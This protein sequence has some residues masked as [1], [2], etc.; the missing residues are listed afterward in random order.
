MH[1]LIIVKLSK[2]Y[3]IAVLGGLLMITNADAAENLSRSPVRSLDGTW[4]IV[5]DGDDAGLKQEWGRAANFPEQQAKAIE[6]PGN[7][8]EALPNYNGVAWYLRRFRSC[9]ARSVRA[10]PGHVMSLMS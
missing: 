5:P 7:T 4:N 6:V 3:T 1:C 10:W 8:Y 9:V 2:V